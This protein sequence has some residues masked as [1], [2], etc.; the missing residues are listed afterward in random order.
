MAS[1]SVDHPDLVERTQGFTSTVLAALGL[2]DR[3]FHLEAFRTPDG[4]LVFLDV[5]A[6]PGGAGIPLRPR[7][8]HGVDLRFQWH[9]GDV[10]IWD[11]LATQH[12]AVSDYWPN[13]RKMERI[14]IEGRPVG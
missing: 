14:T 9:G 1:V 6:R 12:Y 7:M 3:V 4:R 2:T 11:N 13:V 10:A 5:G 8:I